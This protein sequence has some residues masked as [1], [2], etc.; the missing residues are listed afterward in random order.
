V[1]LLSGHRFLQFGCLILIESLWCRPENWWQFSAILYWRN[2]TIQ[3][4]LCFQ[5]W[6]IA[7]QY[8]LRPIFLL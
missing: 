7:A 3:V 6:A 2:V 4:F 8:C 5:R 1:V